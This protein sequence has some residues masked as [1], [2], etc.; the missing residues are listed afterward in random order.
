MIR[1]IVKDPLFLQQKSVLATKEDIKI[2]TD[3]LD[4]LAYHRENCLG[5]AAN[6]IGESKRIIII[7][8]GFVD[9]VMFNPMIISKKDPFHAEESCLSFSGSRKT[10]RYKEIKVDY[11]DHHWMKKLLTLTGLPAQVCQ[12][13]LDHLEGILI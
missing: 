10:T 11:L 4:T 5:M 12:H 6:M 9:L 8:M 7:S 3:L 2:G 1:D 13:E